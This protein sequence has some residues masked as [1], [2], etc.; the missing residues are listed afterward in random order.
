V[1]IRRWRRAFV[2]KGCSRRAVPGFTGHTKPVGGVRFSPDE[3]QVLTWSEDGSVR[4]WPV[5]SVGS[6]IVFASNAGRVWNAAFDRTGFHVIAA[7][8]DGTARVWSV[9]K[10]NHFVLLD[11]REGGSNS[12]LDAAISPDGKSA[13]TVYKGGT[14]LCWQ[15]DG[16]CVPRVLIRSNVQDE[17]LE[18]CAWSYDGKTFAAASSAC[19]VWVWKESWWR[20]R[21]VALRGVGDLA[22]VGSVVGL[23]LS[24]DG[25]Q[26]LTGGSVDGLVRLWRTDGTR[27]PVEFFGAGTVTDASFAPDGKRVLG[28]IESGTV[29][30]WR[31]DWHE[32]VT[33]LRSRTSAT[34]TT[35][36]RVSL[37]GEDG[38]RA[39]SV[40]EEQEHKFARTPLP[41]NW[42]FQYPY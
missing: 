2:E 29:K 15:I 39:R 40:Y 23:A 3:S 12:V 37:L 35:E 5:N 36:Q 13:I 32:L 31:S 9:A 1:R 27:R 20:E 4:L 28:A 11:G 7:Y 24:T 30:I 41:A 6:S 38:S 18:H 22:H 19:R 17:W 25:E 42:T 16:H 21:Q 26:L 10:P 33:F 8:E 34:L 14:A